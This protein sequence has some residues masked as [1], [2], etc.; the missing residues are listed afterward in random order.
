M[1]F[2]YVFSEEDKLHLLAKGFNLINSTKLNGIEAFVFENNKSC[3][4]FSST[5]KQNY[6]FSN[7]LNF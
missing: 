6:L 3:E 2:I 1:K 7:N 4:R 5:E